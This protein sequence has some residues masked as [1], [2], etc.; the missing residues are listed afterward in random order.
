MIPHCRQ[1]RTIEIQY[2]KYSFNCCDRLIG[3]F[4]WNVI[5]SDVIDL[6]RKNHIE[7]DR[8]ELINIA[9]DGII[10]INHFL[11]WFFK[12]VAYH[13]LIGSSN[14]NYAMC[15]LGLQGTINKT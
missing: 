4:H 6:F 2:F 10:V 1:P 5:R 12:I 9:T 11:F 8:L 13:S 3:D 15:I 7:F 14:L